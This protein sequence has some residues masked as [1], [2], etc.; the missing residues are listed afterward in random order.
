MDRTTPYA[1]KVVSGQILKGRTEYLC[2]KRHLDDMANKK[3][4]YIFDVKLAEMAL[5]IRNSIIR[6][7]NN[8]RRMWK[9]FS[10]IS[11]I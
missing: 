3:F 9:R 8:F 11:S 2:C 5:A 6:F 1:K 7:F 4:E 10:K